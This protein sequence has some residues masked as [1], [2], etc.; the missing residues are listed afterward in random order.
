MKKSILAACCAILLALPG[1]MAQ[2]PEQDIRGDYSDAVEAPVR[3]PGLESFFALENNLEELDQSDLASHT[4][5]IGIR[6]DISLEVTDGYLCWKDKD[7]YAEDGVPGDPGY[8][9]FSGMKMN[10]GNDPAGPM[11]INNLVIDTG[12]GNEFSYMAI[13]LPDIIGRVSFDAIKLGD[14]QDMGS[15]LGGWVFGDMYIEHSSFFIR[16]R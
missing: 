1:A 5:Q 11:I 6:I 9:T 3:D 16:T 4:G 14:G 2:S 8:L 13:S 15:S 7:G 10:D 12:Y